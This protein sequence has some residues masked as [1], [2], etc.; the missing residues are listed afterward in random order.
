MASLKSIS[1]RCYL[2]EVEFGWELTRETIHLPLVCLQ[3]GCIAFS[4]D[5]T[6]SASKE[7]SK[8][9]DS[10][11]VI[12]GFSPGS[13]NTMANHDTCRAQGAAFRP[14]D[15]GC[16]VQGAGVCWRAVGGRVPL[17]RVPA[18]R[19]QRG[20]AAACRFPAAPASPMSGPAV[21]TQL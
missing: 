2:R 3:G 20:S 19:L 7:S 8:P 18:R 9:K 13:P 12:W 4:F 15:A 11:S 10:R 6:W 5:E 21:T 16:R 17:R 1:H 14:Q